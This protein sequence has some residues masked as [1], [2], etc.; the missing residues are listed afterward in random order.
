MNV[1]EIDIAEAV[2]RREAGTSVFDVRELDEYVEGHVP[3]APLIPLAAVVD[4]VDEFP[5]GEEVLI[6]CKSGGRSHRAAELLRAR[7]IDAVNIGGGTMAWVEAGHPVATG[8][9]PGS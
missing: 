5:T 2:R 3:G 9:E 7:G 1:P 4:R 8:E 6:I